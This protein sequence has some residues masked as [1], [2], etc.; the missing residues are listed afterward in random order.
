MSHG[1]D[2]GTEINQEADVE[3]IDAIPV[4]EKA[5]TL[6]RML[7]V[8]VALPLFVGVGLAL[9]PVPHGLT[10]IAWRYFALFVTVILWVIAEPLPPA[11]VALAGVVLAA[12]SGLVY[13]SPTQAAAW[14]LSGFGDHTVWL[15]FAAFMFSL[16]YTKTGLGRRIALLLIRAMGKRTLGLGYAIAFADL[17]LAPVMPSNTARSG[18]TIFPVVSQIPG[19]FGERPHDEGPRK[20]GGYLMYTA[21][22]STCVTSSILLTAAAP[23]LLA[24]ELI[25]KT[26]PI[27]ISWAEWFEGFAPVGVVLFLLVPYLLYKIYPPEIKEAPDA[28]RWAGEELRKSGPFTRQETT[29]LVL[30][31]AALALW[32]GG[33]RYIDVTLTAILVVVLMVV[34]GVVTWDDVMGNKQA[35]TVLIWFGALLTMADGLAKTKFV[36]WVANSLMSTFGGLGRIAAI[37]VLVGAFYFLRYLFASGSAAV[38][39]LLPVL[40]GVAVKIPGISPKTWALLFCY[41]IG[42]A[43]IVSPFSGAVSPIYFGCGYIKSRDFWLLGLFFGTVFFVV[44]LLIGIPWLMFLKI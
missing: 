12:I 24:V 22:A 16:G 6:W 38:S 36:D 42:L 25:E 5:V 44:L 37:V 20:I 7:V 19:L 4:T 1:G 27:K 21:L 13:S 8:K 31:I 29:L 40:L 2:T 33:T 10:A 18:G 3:T 39:A 11:A 32:I 9:I 17:A 28:P 30:A 34:L 14:A 35:W 23:N 26:F 41:T 43:T 15:V